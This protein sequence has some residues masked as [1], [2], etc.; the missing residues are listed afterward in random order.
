M[1]WH[2]TQYPG[3]RYR[4]HPTRKNGV[5]FD[6]Y[7]SIRYHLNGRLK[8]EGLG[9]ASKGMS[10]QKASLQLGELKEAQRLGKGAQTLA[11]QRAQA[12]RDAETRESLTFSS[13]FNETYLPLAEAD[14]TKGTMVRE[15]SLFKQ[16]LEPNLGGITLS[17]LS[18]LDLER[19]KKK[20]TDAEQSP[21]SITYALALVRQ[22]INRAKGMNLFEGDNPVNKVR[23][24]SKDNRRMRFLSH[25]EAARLLNELL[26]GG[27]YDIHDMTLLSLYCGLRA[28]EI[29]SLPWDCIDFD[30]GQI[31]IR[32]TKSGR[33][34]IAYMT[35]PVREMLLRRQ[36][37]A[38][39]GLLFQK[40]DGGRIGQIPHTF[41]WTVD[42]LG[43]N[44]GVADRRDKVV[45]HTL[46]HTFASW[47][48]ESGVDLYT[49]KTLLG[50]QTLAMTERYSHLSQGTLQQAVAKLSQSKEGK[51]AKEIVA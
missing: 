10:A 8:E 25:S 24:P 45:F 30:R 42:K 4:T 43:L 26:A 49:V 41:I 16:W 17:R 29:F 9:W 14:K 34:R 13:F 22:V 21:R 51:S 19:L 50:H 12:K 1:K 39:E 33:N 6:Q 31:L 35:G 3:V 36:A 38:S 15:R 44:K 5:K 20:M 11:E 46:R 28:G 47:L 37:T 7:F 18:P 40:P 27:Y 23:K 2:N 48:V 32:D